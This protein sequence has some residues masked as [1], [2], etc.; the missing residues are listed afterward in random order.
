[1][2]AVAGCGADAEGKNMS[3]QNQSAR[4]SFIESSGDRSLTIINESGLYRHIKCHKAGTGCMGF[5]ITTWPGYLAI[6]GDMGC[7]VFARIPDMFEF[8]RGGYHGN[9]NEGYWAEKV[10]AADKNDGLREFDE[11]AA[12][13]WVS[14]RVKDCGDEEINVDRINYDDGM[15]RFFDS[16]PKHDAFTDAWDNN[17]ERYTFRYLWCCYAIVWAIKEYDRVKNVTEGAAK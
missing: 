15:I 5:S 7:Y 4:K 12:R 9:I 16:L 13:E 11:D 8:F 14:Q 17:F 10:Q 2:A 1:M 3:I 6:S